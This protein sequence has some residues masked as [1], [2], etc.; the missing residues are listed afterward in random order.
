MIIWCFFIGIVLF[1]LQKLS[2]YELHKVRIL[3]FEKHEKLAS[4]TLFERQDI[5][6]IFNNN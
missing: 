5:Q 6:D 4:E 2:V 1:I 3:T